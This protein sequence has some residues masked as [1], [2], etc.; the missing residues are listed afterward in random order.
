MAKLINN[1]NSNFAQYTTDNFIIWFANNRT[2]V[3]NAEDNLEKAV[4]KLLQITKDYNFAILTQK[5]GI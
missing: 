5:Y 3:A 1:W 4:Y 2:L